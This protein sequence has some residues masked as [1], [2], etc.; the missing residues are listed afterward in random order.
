MKRVFALDVKVD[1]SLKVKRRVLILIGRGAR[2]SSKEGAKEEEQASSSHVTI[3][4]VDNF[5]RENDWEA[6]QQEPKLLTKT[7]VRSW[8]R[9]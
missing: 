9:I 3:Q 2:A 5:P 6:P 1:D 7:Q 4:E 8:I